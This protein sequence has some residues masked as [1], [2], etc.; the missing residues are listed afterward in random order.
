[1]DLDPKKE[2]GFWTCPVCRNVSSDVILMKTKIDQL[3]QMMGKISDNYDNLSSSMES[4]STSYASLSNSY[5]ELEEKCNSR[6]EDLSK[7]RADC[8]SLRE[9]NKRLRDQVGDL[10]SKMNKASW[11][12]FL[13]D[14]KTLLIGDSLVKDIDPDKLVKTDVVA[15]PG[16]KVGDIMKK[17]DSNKNPYSRIII[18][19]GTNDCAQDSLDY[20]SLN[21]GYKTLINKAIDKVG[22]ASEVVISGIVPR[23][24]SIEHQERV[25]TTNASLVALA[26]DKGVTFVDNDQVFK[27]KDGTVCDMLFKPDGVHLTNRGILQLVRNLK[28]ETKVGH[29]NNVTRFNRQQGRRESVPPKKKDFQDASLSTK[30]S[31]ADGERWQIPKPRRRPGWS[32]Q[33]RYSQ[34]NQSFSPDT[35]S[36]NGK[37]RGYNY[38]NR[39]YKHAEPSTL[40]GFCGEDN[41]R[42]DRCR[43]GEP[44]LC[45]TCG[46]EGHKSKYHSSY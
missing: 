38:S 44:V 46:G 28:I 18:S 5:T 2:N 32:N 15:L 14:K 37:N 10:S 26:V 3:L 11:E 19:A 43:H 39:S 8:D 6:N 40:C 29:E 4:L 1:M 16:A 33:K 35:Q 22:S 34:H 24:D 30:D 21:E 31:D 45:F 42:E 23:S 20:A 7:S 36:Y 12:H 9:E 25:E 27:M 41:H 13:R 17:L